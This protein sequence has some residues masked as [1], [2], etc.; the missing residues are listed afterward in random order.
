V[1]GVAAYLLRVLIALD[2]LA[3]TLAGGVPDETISSRLGKAW[4]GRFGER[5]KRLAQPFR[6]LVNRL[7]FWQRDHCAA[8]IEED[9]GR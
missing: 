1:A 2:Q 4:K 8:S 9:E 5:A 6:W 7:F 3:N